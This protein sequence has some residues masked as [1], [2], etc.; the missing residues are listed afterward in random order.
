METHL[1]IAWNDAMSCLV[2]CDVTLFAAE[3]AL[4]ASNAALEAELAAVTASQVGHGSVRCISIETYSIVLNI[5]F[6]TVFIMDP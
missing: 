6:Y 4:R 1:I 5:R 2:P 3:A